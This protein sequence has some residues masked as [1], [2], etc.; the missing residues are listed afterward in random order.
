MAD[1]REVIG[2]FK[3]RNPYERVLMNVMKWY[4]GHRKLPFQFS[5]W[6][7]LTEWGGCWYPTIGSI[8]EARDLV[9]LIGNNILFRYPE[10]ASSCYYVANYVILEE[11]AAR[12]PMRQQVE[13]HE[14]LVRQLERQGIPAY[15]DYD[16]PYW[17]GVR[18][19][20]SEKEDDRRVNALLTEKGYMVVL[21]EYG[22]K[23]HNLW[24]NILQD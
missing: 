8:E 3:P 16:P 17:L 10:H 1:L 4:L 5:T 24:N 14:A 21:V 9:L 15:L 22:S 20:S 13:R 2:Q 6:V 19:K 7:K 12:K 18:L 23:L 11:V